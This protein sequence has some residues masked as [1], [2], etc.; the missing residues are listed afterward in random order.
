[1]NIETSDYC[2]TISLKRIKVGNCIRIDLS[3][4]WKRFVPIA[5][6]HFL[7]N[8]LE[9]VVQQSIPDCSNFSDPREGFLEPR[10][11]LLAGSLMNALDATHGISHS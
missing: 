8:K 3:C 1:M 4:P 9:A 10:G 6:N 11:Y 5:D 2:A 7:P